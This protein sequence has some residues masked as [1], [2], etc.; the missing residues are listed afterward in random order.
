MNEVYEDR[1]MGSMR[2]GEP[3]RHLYKEAVDE[4]IPAKPS[5]A[6]SLGRHGGRDPLQPHVKDNIYN[7]TLTWLRNFKPWTKH[8]SPVTANGDKDAMTYN[9]WAPGRNIRS[10][11]SDRNL[12]YHL[13]HCSID[14]EDLATRL[15]RHSSGYPSF[16]KSQHVQNSFHGSLHS[17]QKNSEHY[18]EG[19]TYHPRDTSLVSNT[20]SQSLH[21][22]NGYRSQESTFMD[23]YR[24][25]K[26]S[27]EIVYPKSN[28][29]HHEPVFHNRHHQ[30]ASQQYPE[31]HYQCSQDYHCSHKS[32]KTK[33]NKPQQDIDGF[34]VRSQSSNGLHSM[35]SRDGLTARDHPKFQEYLSSMNHCDSLEV[36]NQPSMTNTQ[37][38]A[39][40]SGSTVTRILREKLF[41]RAKSSISITLE[42]GTKLEKQ[43]QLASRG[44]T[45][46]FS[47]HAVGAGETGGVKLRSKKCKT[48]SSDHCYVVNREEKMSRPRSCATLPHYVKLGVVHEN[49]RVVVDAVDHEEVR[50]AP[51]GHG[52]VSPVTVRL[53]NKQRRLSEEVTKRLSLPADI[54][55]PENFLARQTLSLSPDGQLTRRSRRKSLVSVDVVSNSLS[56]AS[57]LMFK[58]GLHHDFIHT[59]Y[60][61]SLCKQRGSLVKLC[62]TIDKGF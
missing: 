44:I 61:R 8:G 30:R 21:R 23:M 56:Y 39:A 25:S 59:F 29:H 2:A 11:K 35:I 32:M 48:S 16:I 47:A 58:W 6:S 53:R 55:L 42:N 4:R 13:K 40:V 26:S 9:N 37:A 54:R 36:Q 34:L 33:G 14:N 50:L 1:R 19:S 17:G 31:N 10:S 24:N 15:G 3:P 62:Y 52:D 18:I 43:Q 27:Q 49:P 20:S 38:A 12:A 60:C 45:N 5:R 28:F 7:K 41:G 51:D 57:V 46:S 22:D